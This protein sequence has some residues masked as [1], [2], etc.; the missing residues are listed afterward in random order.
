MADDRELAARAA[1]GDQRA[2]GEIYDHYAPLV[3][4]ILLDATGSM[5]DASDLVQEVFIRALGRINQLRRGEALGAWLI[6]IARREGIEY[7]RR[8][9]RRRERFSPLIDEA[10]QGDDPSRTYQVDAVRAAIGRL[11]E[12]ER[13]AVHIH[14]LCGEP[15]EAARQTLGLSPSGFYKLLERARELLRAMLLE[16]EERR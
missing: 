7:R 2:A 6:E 3:R 11:P 9:A 12:R 1:A 5:A 13:M 15:A 10:E 16:K 14:Y 8:M 4:A